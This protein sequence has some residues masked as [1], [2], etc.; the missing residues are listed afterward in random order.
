[1]PISS[2]RPGLP[3]LLTLAAILAPRPGLAGQRVIT[4]QVIDRNGEPMERVIVSLDPGNVE[5]VTDQDGNFLIDYL[6]DEDGNR[7]K[8]EKRIDYALEFF[9]TGYHVNKTTFYYK[10]GALILEPVTMAEDTIR[11]APSADDIDP[12]RFPDRTHSAGSNYEG[13]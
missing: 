3:L 9:R 6:R 5:I 7:V 13:E 12:E 11:L 4:G 10:K 8:L 1:M 2:R